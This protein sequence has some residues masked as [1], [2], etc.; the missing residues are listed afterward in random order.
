MSIRCLVERG[1][2]ILVM[3]FDEVERKQR[4]LNARYKVFLGF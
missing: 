2:C 3:F 4:Q 1:D